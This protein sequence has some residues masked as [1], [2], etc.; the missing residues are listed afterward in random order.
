MSLDNSS[1]SRSRSPMDRKI[2]TQRYSY[3]DIERSQEASLSKFK[4]EIQSSQD[5]HFSLLQREAEK[6]RNEIEKMRG[7]LR[8]EIDKATAGQRLDLNLERG[9]IRDEL[10][11]QAQKQETLQTSLIR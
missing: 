9:R 5:H 3:R 2:R 1:R 8:Y 4:S 10:N 6:L 7:E 11:N